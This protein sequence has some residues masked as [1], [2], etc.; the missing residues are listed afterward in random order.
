MYGMAANGPGVMV[1]FDVPDPDMAVA[2]SGVAV[3]SSAA[4]N[5]HLTRLFTMDEVDTI[6]QWVNLSGTYKPPG[7][8]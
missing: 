4:Q 2:I 1:I 3:S 7:Q 8:A 6:R 5:A